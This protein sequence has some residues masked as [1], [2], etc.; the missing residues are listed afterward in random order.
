[1]GFEVILKIDFSNLLVSQ[2][3]GLFLVIKP[4]FV[5]AKRI[6]LVP[7]REL[8]SELLDLLWNI[9]SVGA[10]SGWLFYIDFILPFRWLFICCVLEAPCK[11]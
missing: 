2:L 4:L 10:R 1:M 7:G 11:L 3:L 8:V 5:R 6:D 9:H